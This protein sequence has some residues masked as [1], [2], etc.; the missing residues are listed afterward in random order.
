MSLSRGNNGKPATCRCDLFDFDSCGQKEQQHFFISYTDFAFPRPLFQISRPQKSG[1]NT[2]RLVNDLLKILLNFRCFLNLN[3]LTGT[4]V[5]SQLVRRNITIRNKSDRK[6][7]YC[8]RG[9]KGGGGGGVGINNETEEMT[10]DHFS[11]EK[12]SNLKASFPVMLAS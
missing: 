2:L 10:R 5:Y 8:L 11:P 4:T 6:C 12:N 1:K 7:T 9:G 3:A